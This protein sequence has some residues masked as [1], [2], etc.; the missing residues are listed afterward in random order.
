MGG[1]PTVRNEVHNLGGVVKTARLNKSLTQEQLSEKVGIGR[2]Y[3]MAIENENRKPRFDV[4]FRLI[5]ELGIPADAIFY[6]EREASDSERDQ[7]VRM[8]YLCSNREIRAV[9]A[10]LDVLLES[11]K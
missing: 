1:E 9:T 2:R 7:L 8:L 11:D 6:P 5:R 10:L 4:L 3:L